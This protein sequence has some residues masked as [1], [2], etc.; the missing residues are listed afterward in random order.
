MLMTT[1]EWKSRVQYLKKAPYMH[2]LEE[3]RKEIPKG[4]AVFLKDH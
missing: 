3:W 4:C 2:Q 1:Q